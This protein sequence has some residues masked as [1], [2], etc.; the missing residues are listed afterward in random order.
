MGER[1]ALVFDTEKLERLLLKESNVY[2]YDSSWFYDVVYSGEL[3]NYQSWYDE[4]SDYLCEAT[5]SMIDEVEPQLDHLYGEFVK[6]AARL[7]HRGFQEEREVRIVAIP[8]TTEL[9]QHLKSEQPDAYEPPKKIFKTI[10]KNDDDESEYIELFDFNRG[11]KLPIKRII[12]GP[13]PKKEE[14]A[15][16]VRALVGSRM[17]IDISETPYIG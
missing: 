6:R 5:V 14:N 10:I 16:K 12:V 8:H 4:F 15:K 17:S 3:G 2:Q 7:K 1:Y 11:R 13:H 9:D